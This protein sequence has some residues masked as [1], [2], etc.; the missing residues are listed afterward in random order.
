MNCP[1]CNGEVQ[2][3]AENDSYHC[4]T[5]QQYFRIAG[6]PAPATPQ[7]NAPAGRSDFAIGVMDR[8][9]QQQPAQLD[10]NDRIIGTVDMAR[11]ANDSNYFR[12]YFTPN[13]LIYVHVPTYLSGRGPLVGRALESV[14]T[15]GKRRSFREI[16]E[17]ITHGVQ[18]KQAFDKY[19]SHPKPTIVSINVK[20]GLGDYVVTIEL[21][22]KKGMF[23]DKKD[24]K[25]FLIGKKEYKNIKEFLPGYYGDISTIK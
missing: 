16:V 14:S 17:G 5:C 19:A 10:P 6:T 18:V 1:N 8:H 3:V 20:R 4:R 2:Y 12:L 9:F 22:P 11:R 21:P 23:G 24:I 15:Y 7:M 25:K 13:E